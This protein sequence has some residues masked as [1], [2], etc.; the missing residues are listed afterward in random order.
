MGWGRHA[1]RP[2]GEDKRDGAEAEAAVMPSERAVE[3]AAGRGWDEDDQGHG[4]KGRRGRRR[5][6]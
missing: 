3:E 4:G 2:D 6:L 1:G 5:S